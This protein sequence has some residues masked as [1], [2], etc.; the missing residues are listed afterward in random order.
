MWRIKDLFPF[1]IEC[2]NYVLLSSFGLS[3]P[4]CVL[5]MCFSALLT[6]IPSIL[7]F[8]FLFVINYSTWSRHI[9]NVKFMMRNIRMNVCLFCNIDTC[10]NDE[11]YLVNF[12]TWLINGVNLTPI[13][14]RKSQNWLIK[15]LFNYFE[16]VNFQP[17]YYWWRSTSNSF[18]K[19]FINW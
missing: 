12:V 10:E 3:T 2:I 7:I 13:V 16:L 19:I 14:G 11:W 8:T 1:F 6:S 4:N 18:R 9:K 17:R 15:V 5:P